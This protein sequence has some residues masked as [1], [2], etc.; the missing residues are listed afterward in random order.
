MQRWNFGGVEICRM[1]CR[2][3]APYSLT[4]PAFAVDSAIDYAGSPAWF[5]TRQHGPALSITEG[6]TNGAIFLLGSGSGSGCLLAPLKLLQYL[7]S[8]LGHGSRT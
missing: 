3:Q 2:Q 6:T 8:E 5:F 1:H 4:I 7:G